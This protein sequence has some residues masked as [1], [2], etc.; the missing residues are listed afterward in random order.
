MVEKDSV[1]CR[2]GSDLGRYLRLTASAGESR[3]CL[4]F[5]ASASILTHLGDRSVR[6]QGSL[7]E[8]NG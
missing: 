1:A 7:Q 3:R 4:R 6:Q 5:A 8:E 2:I